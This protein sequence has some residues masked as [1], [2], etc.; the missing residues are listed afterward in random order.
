MS[1]KTIVGMVDRL[2]SAGSGPSEAEI[3][4]V[5]AYLAPGPM[6]AEMLSLLGNPEVMAAREAAQA[7]LRERDWANLGQYREANVALGGV[8]QKA[9]FMGDSI[10]EFWSAGDAE[11][12]TGG[13]VC[14]GISG[15]TSP[16]MLLR[17][18]ADV[19][20]LKPAAVH[21]LAGGN[22]MAGNTGPTTL[23]DYQ[24]NITA[25]VTL[26]LAQGLR[27]IL[28]SITPASGFSWR[29]GI[30]P[31]SRIAQINAWLKALAG[32][33]GLIY[34]DY[35]SA[36]AAPDGSMRAEFARDGVHP[37]A[38]GYAVMRPI[39]LAALALAMR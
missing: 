38:A 7:A 30:D 12:F 37:T 35:H 14:R 1:D 26:A 19:I 13:V 28:G 9:V 29:P 16:Q 24:N 10:T 22:D 11:L 23:A 3:A 21:L 6:P 25:M 32:E 33:R 5:R 20:A 36:L 31:R 39:A 18:M 34:A 15:Q 17:F 2:D 8:A 27:V 4:F